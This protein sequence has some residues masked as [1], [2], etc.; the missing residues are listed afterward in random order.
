MMSSL[1]RS[2]SESTFVPAASSGLCR[3]R[4]ENPYQPAGGALQSLRRT[5]LP[6]GT[7][8]RCRSGS[9]GLEDVVSVSIVSPSP[10]E[11]GWVLNQRRRAAALADLYELA[12]PGYG[13]RSTVPVLWDKQ[14][15]HRQLMQRL[16]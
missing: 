1:P 16:S 6:L 11:G 10:I 3:D 5:Q 14:T 8:D 4:E 13:G 2:E 7:P 12:E 15:D 9:Q